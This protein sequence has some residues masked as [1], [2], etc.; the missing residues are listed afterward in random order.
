MN[1]N[2]NSVVQLAIEIQN[3]MTKHDS[4]NVKITAIPKRII[5]GILAHARVRTESI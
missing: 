2:A 3:G 4:V 5:V 1:A